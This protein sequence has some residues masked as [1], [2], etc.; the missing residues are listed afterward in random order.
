MENI[1]YMRE[2][3]ATLIGTQGIF[4]RTLEEN[5]T[6]A[7]YGLAGRTSVDIPYLSPANDRINLN[8]DMR[9]FYSDF[10][11]VMSEAKKKVIA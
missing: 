6:S 3:I 5:P 10:G 8:A 11:K 2:V 1:R 9:R 4:I 7:S